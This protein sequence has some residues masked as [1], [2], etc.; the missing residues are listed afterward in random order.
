MAALHFDGQTW[1]KI[2]MLD[3]ATLHVGGPSDAIPYMAWGSGPDDIWLGVTDWEPIPGNPGSN[4]SRALFVHWDGMRWS[5]DATL[6]ASLAAS[7]LLTSMWGNNENDIWAVGEIEG[8]AD[9]T[10][11]AVHWDGMRWSEVTTIPAKDLADGF[12]SVWSSGPNDLWIGGRNT[13]HHWDG[14]TWTQVSDA[15]AGGYLVSGSGPKD[16]W[17]IGAKSDGSGVSM[18]W[19]GTSWHTA[20]VPLIYPNAVVGISPTNVWVKSDDGMAHWDGQ[21]WTASDAGT[22]FSSE[23]LWWDGKDVWT[24]VLQGLIRHP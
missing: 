10:G 20:D 12:T 5:A 3:A 4:T 18:H 6:D 22:T 2:E 21:A 8:G 23:N 7:M 14:Q 17:A 19:D 13:V 11:S 16:V 15:D 9:F 24:I 1:S